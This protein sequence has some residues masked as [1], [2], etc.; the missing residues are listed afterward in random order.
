MHLSIEI[1]REEPLKRKIW[2]FT[3]FSTTFVLSEYKD[4]YKM[5]PSRNWRTK[6]LYD[7]IMHRENTIEDEQ[8]EIPEDVEAELLE[9]FI[10]SLTV[11]IWKD[12]SKQNN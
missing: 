1:T 2:V 8:I 6:H 7:R 11:T 3:L 10:G 4:Q 12:Y 9:K 5:P